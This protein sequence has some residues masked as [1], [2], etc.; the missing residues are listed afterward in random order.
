MKA[1]SIMIIAGVIA[2]TGVGLLLYGTGAGTP[3]GIDVKNA[4]QVA[5]GK[6]LYAQECASCHGNDLQGQT[7]NWRQ[8]LPD[9]SLPAPPHNASG[10]TWHHPDEIL[11][12]ITKYGRLQAARRSIRS[13]MLAFEK[14]LSDAEIWAVLSYIKSRWPDSIR[15]RHDDMNTRYRASR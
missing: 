1:G 12:E 8:R 5:Q 3:S 6:S 14:K 11:F 9:G 15:Q 7:R 4:E 10:H 2:L 13:N